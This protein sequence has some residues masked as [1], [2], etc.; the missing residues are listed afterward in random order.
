MKIFKPLFTLIVFSILVYSCSSDDNN[1]DNG[2]EQLANEQNQLE[3]IPV[4]LANLN[5]DI[6]I[7]GATKNQGTPPAPNSN[8]NL[9]I[10]SDKAEA[11]QSF[12]FNLKFSTVEANVAGAYLLFKDSDNNNASDYFDIPVSS[13][14][15]NKSIKSNKSRG[16]LKKSSKTL[17]DDEYEIDVDFGN[18]FPPGKFCADLCIYD[19]ENNISQIVTV[20]IEVEAWGGNAAIT[21]EWVFDRSL[22]DNENDEKTEVTCEN[23]E[24][25]IVDEHIGETTWTLVLNENGSYYETYKGTFQYLDYKA[26]VTSCT[27]E[28][29]NKEE[30]EKY[31]GNWAYNEEKETLT[32]IDFKFEDFLDS[33]NNETNENGDIYFD[34]ENVTASIVN[35]ELVITGT[36]TEAGQTYTDTSIFK[37]K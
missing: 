26:T 13:F 20:C 2:N 27:A 1:N 16:P 28:Y 24:T 12:G 5:S 14:K 10:S 6:S 23:E 3:E 19:S 9:E 34:G 33:S 25:I 7:D 18:S 15:T 21:G 17:I 35:G 36:Y 31:S 37:R 8:I 22:D 30:D 29:T 4:P 32:I 11:F